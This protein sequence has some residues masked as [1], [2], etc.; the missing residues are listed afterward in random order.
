MNNLFLEDEFE[1]SLLF[2]YL[3]RGR[4]GQKGMEGC[5]ILQPQLTVTK[6]IPQCTLKENGRAPTLFST[7]S[8]TSQ[9]LPS[10]FLLPFSVTR[11]KIIH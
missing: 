1:A 6:Q 8:F 11:M 7:L 2:I 3:F 10:Y 4:G 9:L 5:R